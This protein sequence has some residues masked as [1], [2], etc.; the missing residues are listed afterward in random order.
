M[1]SNNLKQKDL[2]PEDMPR[3]LWVTL[4]ALILSTL[5]G[6]GFFA[7]AEARID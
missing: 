4:I 1:E 7:V 5:T 3:A 2:P 6:T